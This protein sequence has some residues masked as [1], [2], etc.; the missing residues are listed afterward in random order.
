ML[1]KKIKTVRSVLLEIKNENVFVSVC[2]K[3]V[4]K[5]AVACI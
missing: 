4:F 3:S 1:L 2:N 5:F